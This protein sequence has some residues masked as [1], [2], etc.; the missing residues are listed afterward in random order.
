M[1][2]GPGRA[3]KLRGN[4]K[5]ISWYRLQRE[6]LPSKPVPARPQQFVMR[7]WRRCSTHKRGYREK[8]GGQR[9]EEMPPVPAAAARNIKN[10][11]VNKP[12]PHMTGGESSSAP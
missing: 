8:G 12:V 4:R 10:V 3:N 11:V 5:V 2:P 6:P 1:F 7:P 9:L